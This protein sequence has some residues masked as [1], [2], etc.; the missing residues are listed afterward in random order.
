MPSNEENCLCK[1]QR[2]QVRRVILREH[3]MAGKIRCSRHRTN[4][5]SGNFK[6]IQVIPQNTG[7]PGEP[8]HTSEIKDEITLNER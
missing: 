8:H 2:N 6:H 3:S 7:S 1:I 5:Y 4:D